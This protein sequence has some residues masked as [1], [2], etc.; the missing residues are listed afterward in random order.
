M[1]LCGFVRYGSKL[2]SCLK[3]AAAR[4]AS[5]PAPESLP[6]PPPVVSFEIGFVNNEIEVSP[7]DNEIEDDLDAGEFERE[8]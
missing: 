5:T 6:P 3:R 8:L 2:R 4:R 1:L 7:W